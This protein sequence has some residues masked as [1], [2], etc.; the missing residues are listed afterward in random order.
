MTGQDIQD[1]VDALVSDLQTKG[2]GQTIQIA[3]RD[4]DR[5][6]GIYPLSSDARGVVNAQ[7]LG[8]I[9]NFADAAKGAADVYE[10]AS[11]PVKTALEAFRQAQE[12]HEALMQTASA[13][14]KNLNDAL[15]T[16]ATYQ[17]AKTAL[18]AARGEQDYIDAS[19][20][21]KT[22]GVSEIYSNLQDARG[23]YVV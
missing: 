17:A 15:L 14:R 7:Q 21:Y 16:D 22:V 13:A 19:A 20:T 3:I 10:A 12:P 11:V 23:K 6:L 18:D 5:N 4:E 2:K 9:Q 8:V 1:R